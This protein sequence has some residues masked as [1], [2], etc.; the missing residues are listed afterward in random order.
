MTQ[1]KIRKL[2]NEIVELELK[3]QNPSISKEE[4][5]QVEK[6]IIQLTNTISVLPNGMDILIQIDELIY[7][8]LKN[9]NKKE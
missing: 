4:K 6:R 5:D 2:A 1:K 8:K 7:D 9:N 3:H